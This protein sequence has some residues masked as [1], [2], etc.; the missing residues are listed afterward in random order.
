VVPRDLRDYDHAAL[1]H[2]LKSSNQV[3]C[4]FVFDTEIL[5]QLTDKAYRRVEFIW[6]SVCALKSNSKQS[7]IEILS[8]EPATDTMQRWCDKGSMLG[9]VA[10]GLLAL[11]L[12]QDSSAFCSLPS[13]QSHPLAAHQAGQA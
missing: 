5:A 9:P 12:Y 3:Y 13:H 1:Y 11:G 6:E 2:V 8:G 7:N 10:P 4:A